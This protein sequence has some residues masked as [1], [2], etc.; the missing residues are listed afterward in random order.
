VRTV[1]RL[2][3]AMNC[4]RRVVVNV[5]NKSFQAILAHDAS[6]KF[7]GRLERVDACFLLA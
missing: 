6:P 7:S 3:Q 2:H 4:S 1:E 5:P